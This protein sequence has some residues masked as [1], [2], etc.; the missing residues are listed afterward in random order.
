MLES[1]PTMRFA[2]FPAFFDRPE[3]M[4]FGEQEADEKVELFLRRHWITNLPWIFTSLF[5]FALPAIIIQLVRTFDINFFSIPPQI[6]FGSIILWYLVILGYVL[7]Q[8]L[9][10]YYNIY[11]VTTKHLVD[12][13]FHSLLYRDVTESALDDIQSVSSKIQG[14]FG[15]LFNYGDVIAQTA[16]ETHIISFLDVPFPDFVADRIEDLRANHHI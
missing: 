13:N 16:A 15:S 1:F 14:I 10:W 5:G 7:E 8:F 9:Y 3:N 11:I 2:L 12:I 4:S 6:A